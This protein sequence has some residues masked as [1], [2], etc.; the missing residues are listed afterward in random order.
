MRERTDEDD[1]GTS[2][3]MLLL[4]YYRIYVVHVMFFSRSVVKHATAI[5]FENML[6]SL[7]V[8]TCTCK[9][10]ECGFRR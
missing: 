3:I 5:L 4:L 6:N 8:C 9:M 2:I 1:G 10:V 7:H